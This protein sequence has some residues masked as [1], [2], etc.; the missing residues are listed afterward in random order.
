MAFL[1]NALPADA[2]AG[3]ASGEPAA[4]RGARFEVALRELCAAAPYALQ[5]AAV[6]SYHFDANSPSLL[7]QEGVVAHL[8]TSRHGGIVIGSPNK[9]VPQ[10]SG[11]VSAAPSNLAAYGCQHAK[12]LI[13]SYRSETSAA[14]HPPFLRVAILSNNLLQRD[15]GR[16]TGSLFVQ[17]FPMLGVGTGAGAG[18]AAK[19]PSQSAAAAFREPLLR[20]LAAL[21]MPGKPAGKPGPNTLELR[22]MLDR[23]DFASAKAV[24]IA[25]Y[26]GVRGV[27]GGHLALRHALRAGQ[28]AG[29][30][31]IVAQ[32]SSLGSTKLPFLR[33]FCESCQGGARPRADDD[34]QALA[35][36]RKSLRVVLPSAAFVRNSNEG[37]AAGDAVPIAADKVEL[38]SRSA[39]LRAYASDVSGRALSSPHIKTLLSPAESD[40]D[41]EAAL[42]A[43][44]GS[45]AGR[46][47]GRIRWLLTGSHNLGPAAWGSTVNARGEMLAPLSYE[48]SVLL[49]PEL[50]AQGVRAEARAIEQRRLRASRFT[51]THQEAVLAARCATEPRSEPLFCALFAR[52]AAEHHGPPTAKRP[53]TDS[54]DEALFFLP[55]PFRFLLDAPIMDH[56]WTHDGLAPGLP[57]RGDDM[58]LDRY[59]RSKEQGLRVGALSRLEAIPGVPGAARA[60]PQPAAREHDWG[61]AGQLLGAHALGAGPPL[62]PP[63]PPLAG[64]PDA[65]A[66]RRLLLADAAQRRVAWLCGDSTGAGSSSSSSSSSS[67]SAI[68]GTAS[69]RSAHSAG[70]AIG[71]SSAS[72]SSGGPSAV[73]SAGGGRSDPVCLLDEDAPV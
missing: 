44:S 42:G 6:A 5:Y 41:G 4:Q 27:E 68:A 25:S 61:P 53:R 56:V 2:L 67:A 58:L 10:L 49:M 16:K 59:G 57:G 37:W 72:A 38:L 22:N 19:A 46:G 66:R 62:P 14:E 7:E 64:G 32:V 17:D 15:F 40:A 52:P 51:A 12:F 39:E 47:G 35:H 9:F 48:L 26:P 55:V 70:G 45:E 3:A 36:V 23:T 1:L 8:R 24:V 71:S 31:R 30:A 20:F 69:P 33:A 43:V 29:P 54:S 34:A 18:A 50:Y 60:Q 21:S 63:P 28:L 65:A 13:L 73:V 11:F